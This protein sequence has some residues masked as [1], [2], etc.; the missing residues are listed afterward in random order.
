MPSFGTRLV[1]AS[2]EVDLSTIRVATSAR[3]A[4]VVA[5][6]LTVGF[7]LDLIQAG[8]SAAMAA[9]LVG[10]LDKGP[11]PR[12][13]RRAMITSTALFTLITLAAGLTSH[14]P[15]VNFVLM[16]LLA[17][18][19]GIGFSVNP[20]STQVLVFAAVMAAGY[21]IKPITPDTAVAAAVGV[22]LAGSLQTVL[23]LVTG[24]LIRDWPER[25]QVIFAMKSVRDLLTEVGRGIDTLNSARNASREMEQAQRTL[26]ASDLPADRL[27][28]YWLILD[29]ID[30]MRLEARG[31]AGRS[32]LGF[33]ISRERESRAALT[34][35]A[36]VLQTAITALMC[37]FTRAGSECRTMRRGV[38]ELDSIADVSDP[39]DARDRLRSVAGTVAGDCSHLAGVIEPMVSER[40]RHRVARPAAE[41]L[42]R[43]LRAALQPGSVA[44][45]HALRLA[46]AAIT[47][48]VIGRALGLSYSSWVAVTAMMILRPDVGPTIPRIITRALGATI[49]VGAVVIAFVPG[50]D[51]EP[52]M[53]VWVLLLAWCVFTFAPV[54]N[55]LMTGL[56]TTLVISLLAIAG[57]DPQQVAAERLFD[58]IVGCAV[59]TGFAL[60]VPVWTRDRL[61]TAVGEYCRAAAGYLRAIGES[62]VDPQGP[63][64]APDE[65]RARGRQARTAGRTAEADL[66]T[67]LL[68]PGSRNVR[69]EEVS[70]VIAWVQRANE[71]GVVAE[72]SLRHDQPAGPRS[73]ELAELAACEL[74][75][76]AAAITALPVSPAPIALR[77][78]TS[79]APGSESTGPNLIVDD[80]RDSN[81]VD[82]CLTRAARCA[83][84]AHRAAERT[85]RRST[86]A[87]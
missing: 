62:T 21:S 86:R 78:T 45:R 73:V 68:E 85:S 32:R 77:A 53:V 81:S 20:R 65:I 17:A 67:S 66:R 11:S 8:V 52:I 27:D 7:H 31:L 9:L 72:V 64:R 69:P 30:S 71:A 54:N 79:R 26:A 19:A 47:G 13:A 24:P 10:L 44:R 82:M 35:G 29:D 28:Q 23:V 36:A 42:A 55:A 59:G 80:A 70:I 74:E 4:L 40:S 49:G 33:P 50:W 38:A 83:Q 43:R 75:S 39:P 48:E 34:A 60:L 84:A 87:T 15:I 1:A 18:L 22:L 58:V 5:G 25:R 56:M 12:Q 3:R 2:I 14:L 61:R 63:H 57:R 76:T 41:P 6:A 51:S 16:A 46:G 37:R